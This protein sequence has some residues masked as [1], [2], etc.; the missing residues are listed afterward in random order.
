MKL[1]ITRNRNKPITGEKIVFWEEKE[2]PT[3]I[4]GIYWGNYF[5]EMSLRD[6]IKLFRYFPEEGSRELKDIEVIVKTVN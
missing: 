6:F 4:D 5:I 2:K 1:W 3:V